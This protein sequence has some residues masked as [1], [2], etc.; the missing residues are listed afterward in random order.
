MIANSIVAQLPPREP[1]LVVAV[2]LLLAVAITPFIDNVSTA[3][4]LSPIAAGVATRAGVPIEPLLMA[5]AI[6]ASL[7]FLT[8]FGHH[9]NAVVMGAAG[10]RFTDFPRL[11]APLLA[12]CVVTAILFLWL[13]WF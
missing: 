13:V 11:G 2:M 10:Y 6:G 4:V 9:N 3:A 8:P 1:L 7:D 5:V 12:I